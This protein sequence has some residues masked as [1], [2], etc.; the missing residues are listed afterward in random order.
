MT[1]PRRTRH[2]LA[3]LSRVIVS[4]SSQCA[5]ARLKTS[6]V[7]GHTFVE[8]VQH[9]SGVAQPDAFTHLMAAAESDYLF[10][11]SG[12][13]GVNATE[14]HRVAKAQRVVTFLRL[15]EPSLPSVD[16]EHPATL[17]LAPSPRKVLGLL[18]NESGRSQFSVPFAK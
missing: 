2:A 16:R 4:P 15:G 14:S 5:K 12:S 8:F 1:A 11:Y 7:V 3:T 18:V 6:S 13:D 17:A 9:H 10:E